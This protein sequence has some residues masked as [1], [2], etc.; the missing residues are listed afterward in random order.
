[1]NFGLTC[2]TQF[3]I[4]QAFQ[5]L[6]SEAVSG[7]WDSKLSC[8]TF[9]TFSVLAFW[10]APW[11]HIP[12]SK[13]EKPC[14][15][16]GHTGNHMLITQAT[17]HQT[18]YCVASTLLLL[19]RMQPSGWSHSH[20]FSSN[21]FSEATV[22]NLFYAESLLH[23]KSRLQDRAGQRIIVTHSCASNTWWL[24]PTCPSH[25]WRLSIHGRSWTS[26]KTH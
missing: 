7:I 22:P 21:F 15:C 11:Y 6:Y 8:F 1:M 19:I 16:L 3:F 12:K 10:T 5:R 9:L 26:S 25:A 14:P 18:F 2:T 13:H 20:R 17:K 23:C 24:L 4:V